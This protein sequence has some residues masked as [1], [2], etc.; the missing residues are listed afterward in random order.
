MCLQANCS[1]VRSSHFSAADPHPELLDAMKDYLL[2]FCFTYILEIHVS[3][4]VRMITSTYKPFPISQVET[5]QPPQ[6]K[7]TY[8]LSTMDRCWSGLSPQSGNKFW[9]EEPWY[10]L[11]TALCNATFSKYTLNKKTFPTI[12]SLHVASTGIDPTLPLNRRFLQQN[13]CWARG[14]M[15]LAPKRCIHVHI[16]QQM[17]GHY[18]SIHTSKQKPCFR[19]RRLH[20][21]LLA[22]KLW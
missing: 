10:T 20:C 5:G 11:L 3:S 16:P 15:R 4:H 21:I 1:W 18:A 2:S 7:A 19:P 6:F 8:E 17:K 14:P 13:T 9:K 22:G 12:S